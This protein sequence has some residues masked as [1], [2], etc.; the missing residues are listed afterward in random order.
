M[1]AL[2]RALA[3]LGA[4]ALI[5]SPAL[6][7]AHAVEAALAIEAPGRAVWREAPVPVPAEGEVLVRILG[8]IQPVIPH[9][10]AYL[11]LVETNA[12]GNIET[13]SNTP[14][15]SQ[16]GL[17]TFSPMGEEQVTKDSML[18]QLW[19]DHIGRPPDPS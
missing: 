10:A 9:H 11:V 7:F 5:S 6:A 2:L 15:S 1:P 8:H 12:T 17:R 14:L 4:V 19:R 3:A 13:P 16:T 18:R